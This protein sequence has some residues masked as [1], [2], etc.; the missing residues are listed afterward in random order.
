[1]N[2]YWKAYFPDD[3]ETPDGATVLRPPALRGIYTA[4][5]AAE[6]ACEYDYGNRDGWERNGETFLI[7]IIAPDGSETC[8]SARHEPMIHHSVE[9]IA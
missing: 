6:I 3:G 1:M 9:E 4:E 8:W 2:E 7:H 5:D